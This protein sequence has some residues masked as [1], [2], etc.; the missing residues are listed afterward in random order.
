MKV[1]EG[2]IDR[3]VRVV[4]A[5]VLVAAGFFGTRG[6]WSIVLYVL[7]AIMLVTGAVGTCPLYMPFGINTAKKS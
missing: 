5:V 7:A 3:V 2:T 4:L 1:N 6:V